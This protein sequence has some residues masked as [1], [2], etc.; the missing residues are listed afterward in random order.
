M[1]LSNVY[2]NN[3]CYSISYDTGHNTRELI[4]LIFTTKTKAEEWLLKQPA[5]YF[6]DPQI[7]KLKPQ[8][9]K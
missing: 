6:L 5:D 7:V 4:N 3:K 1:K 9:I 2:Q 8:L